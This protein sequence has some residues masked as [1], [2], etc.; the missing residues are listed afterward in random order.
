MLQ[1]D[2]SNIKSELSK[3]IFLQEASPKEVS[4]ASVKKDISNLITELESLEKKMKDKEE[5][6]QVKMKRLMAEYTSEM[7][8]LR[9]EVQK[10]RKQLE[11]ELKQFKN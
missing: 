8:D 1:T 7:N 10:K 4:S 2:A 3:L 6:F 5:D 9:T 11:L